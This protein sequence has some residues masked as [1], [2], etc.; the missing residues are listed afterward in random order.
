MFDEVKLIDVS[1]NRVC[2]LNSVEV[3]DKVT[4]WAKEFDKEFGKN[5]WQRSYHDHII[6]DDAD[7][8]MIWQYIDTNPTRWE[9]DCFYTEE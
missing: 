8:D 4:A 7:Y 3:Y 9:L 6:R 2:K 1:K 5:I